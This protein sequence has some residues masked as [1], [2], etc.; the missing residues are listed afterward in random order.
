MAQNDTPQNAPE[1]QGSPAAPPTEVR[2]YVPFGIR[3]SAA[4]SWRLILIVVA[5]A[6]FLWLVVTLRIVVIPVVIAAL[7]AALLMPLQ[8]RLIAWKLP[9][10]LAVTITLL[11]LIAGV[12]LLLVLIITQF[13]EGLGGLGQRTEE[14]YHEFLLWLSGD[15]FHFSK[16]Q[17]DT[18]INDFI[19]GFNADRSFFL[20]G[21]LSVTSTLTHVLAGLLLTIFTTLFFLIDGARIWRWF[22]GF[23]PTR[24]RAATD[25]AGRAGW[26][27]VGQYVRVQILVAFV[28][29]VG[30]GLGAG[31]LQVPLAIPIA[32]MVFLGS[33]VPFLGA[34]TTG[35]IAAFVALI[36]NGPVNALIM[37][38]IVILVNQVEGHVLQ[39]LVMGSAVR[40]HP[41]GVVLAV[42]IGTL[43][44]G[45]PGALFAVPIAAALN[46]MVNYLTSGVWK[47]KPDPLA[48][49]HPTGL[50]GRPT[51]AVAP[52][53]ADLEK[54]VE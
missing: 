36:Y 49:S 32:I 24:A 19:E 31:I 7:L 29:A 16:K 43:V 23:M 14:A 45:I 4:W 41:L 38:G 46:S 35:A 9:K 54:S 30:I 47:G 48:H 11:S 18:T 50:A 6:G 42:S 20:N 1:P 40:V 10:W 28:D 51:P 39:P 33:F 21:A 27:S 53:P 13:R 25:G 37:L 44:A 15:P 8:N 52:T 17:V 2:D 12:G 22:V 3:I 34:I 26:V 5:L